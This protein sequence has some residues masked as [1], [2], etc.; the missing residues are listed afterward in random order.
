MAREFGRE[1]Q[2]NLGF[3][4]MDDPFTDDNQRLTSPQEWE[5]IQQQS[6]PPWQV[7][8]TSDDYVDYTWHAPTVRL[9]TARPRLKSPEPSFAYP[10]WVVNA[11][12]GVRECIDPGMFVAGKTIAATLV[13]LLTK[14][15]KAQAEF[16]ERTGG[17]IGGG[18]W[19]APH[20]WQLY[21]AHHKYLHD[22]SI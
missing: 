20:V 7:N 6:L 10:A 17:G 16:K 22:F 12:G 5:D 21:W 14:L 9:H 13:D 11:M 2:K 4:P 15:Q 19:V 1:I 3:D 8:F 18:K